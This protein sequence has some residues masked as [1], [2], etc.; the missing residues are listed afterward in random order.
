[1]PNNT[2]N[3]DLIDTNYPTVYT[4]INSYDVNN[5]PFI[6][7]KLW[8]ISSG[9]LTT[10]V[11]PLTAIYLISSSNAYGKVGD[12]NLPNEYSKNVDGS[13]KISTYFSINH[14]FYK[15]KDQ[16]FNTFGPSDTN[17]VQKFLYQSASVF[18]IP[19]TKVGAKIKPTSF[20]FTASSSPYIFNLKDDKYGNVYDINFPLTSIVSKCV[21]YEGFNEY[22]DTTRIKYY[23]KN[24]TYIDGINITGSLLTNE[25]IGHAASFVGNGFISQ[26]INGEYS[27]DTDYAISFFIKPNSNAG[28]KLVLG[29]LNSAQSTKYPFKIELNSTNKILFT[30]AATSQLKMTVSQSVTASVWNHVVCQKSGSNMY[31]HVNGINI[32]SQSNPAFA[33]QTSVNDGNANINNNSPLYIGGFSTISSNLTADLDEVRIFNKSL[34]I[35]DIN[36]L[37]DRSANGTCLQ[38]NI[39]GNV[40]HDHGMVVISSPNP[41]Y[42]DIIN[43]PG[44]KAYY[45][46]TL[47]TNEFSALIR[48]PAGQY[49]MSLNPSMLRDDNETYQPY[50]S[51][52]DF[53]PYITTIGLYNSSGS[54]M[55]VAK[56]AQPIKKRN[57]MDLNFLI[58]IDLDQPIK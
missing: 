44:Y 24:V 17:R 8:D 32:A 49:N 54:L 36:A 43:I 58:Q 9:S 53:S 1:M 22:F 57:D 30:A 2:T 51:G 21:F 45:R 10:S 29:K 33:L 26:S 39:V 16:P 6:S 55:A 12:P 28:T 37:K 19:N 18:S 4:S 50:V 13:L 11:L 27:R 15:R 41:L 5:K 38:T 20:E 48:V 56:L 31:V 14:L 34:N 46:S 25:P 40:F 52:S 3:S 47:K 7:N 42:K 35:N 23:Y